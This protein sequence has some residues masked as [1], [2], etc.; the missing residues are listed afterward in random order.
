LQGVALDIGG[1]TVTFQ[2]DTGTDFLFDLPFLLLTVIASEGSSDLW[3]ITPD[4]MTPDG[5]SCSENSSVYSYIPSP[6]F[7]SLN[8]PLKIEYGSEASLTF[9]SGWLTCSSDFELA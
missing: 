3:S 2:L 6:S 5:Q 7:Q 8:L 4:C 1:Q 9:A